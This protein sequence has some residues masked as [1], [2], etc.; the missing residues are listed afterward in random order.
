[1]RLGK[2]T[3]LPWTVAAALSLASTGLAHGQS[4]CEEAF[5]QAEKSYNLGLFEDVPDQLAP[6]LGA[7]TSRALAVQVHYL[8]ARTYLASDELDKARQEIS[9]ILRIDSSF[10]PAG[11]P[12]RFAE[13]IAEI[14]REEATVQVTSV[15]KTKES[16]REVP[17]TVVVITADEIE[18]RGY[19]DLE[20]LLHDLPGFDISRTNG[21]FYS[22]I[23]QRGFRSRY[24]DRNLFLLDG[25]EQNDPSSNVLYLSRQYPLSNIDRV[26][27][28]YGPA[29]T[30]YGANAYTGVINIIT[31][32]P[33]DL[34]GADQRFGI[35]VQ[36][37]AGGFDARSADLSLAGKDRNGNLAWSLAGHLYRSD[38]MDLSRFENWNFKYDAIDYRSLLSLAG[39][40]AQ[41]F[42]FLCSGS[43]S[44]Y[45]DCRFDEGGTLTAIELTSAG[46][47]VARALD[48]SFIQENQ[49]HF[50]D[51]TDDWALYGKMRIA[52]LT[53]G[54]DVWRVDEGLAS[55]FI[56]LFVDGR[57]T[58]TSRQLSFYLQYSRSAG[59][60]LTFNAFTRF[61]QFAIDKAATDIS[62]PHLYANSL[63]GIWNLVPPCALPGDPVEPSGCPASPWFEQRLYGGTSSQIRSEYTLVYEPAGKLSAVGGLELARG[64]IGVQD[65]VATGPGGVTLFEI[66]P[67]QIEHTDLGLYAQA[68]YKLRS[69]LK[70]VLA[71]RLSYNEINNK[72]SASGFGTLF[73]PRMAIVYTPGRR[74][75]KAIYSEAFKD[76]TDF[77]KFGTLP[78][79]YDFPS[80]GL[81]PEKVKNF[82]VSAGWQPTDA[83]SLEAAAYEARYT[84]LVTLRRVPGCVQ[85]FGCN[86]LQNHDQLRIRG[87]QVTAQYR[88]GRVGLWSNYTYTNPV[89]RNPEDADGQPLLDNQGNVIDE[90]RVADIASHRVNLGLDFDFLTRFKAD[91]RLHYIGPRPTGRGT[92]VAANPLSQIDSSTV[93]DAALSYVDLLPGMT[94]Q[95]IVN[96]LFDREYFDPGRDVESIGAPEVPQP[97]RTVYLRI[98]T[99]PWRAGRPAE[100]RLGTAPGQ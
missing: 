13:L 74:V 48:R 92:T 18:R 89:Q 83:L 51:R 58:S 1:M 22:N 27:V 87:L 37:A 59:R 88:V 34:I 91:L 24:S 47:Q 72:P 99:R 71:G 31:K 67:E 68:S 69:M 57:S 29:S 39:P 96:N 65:L 80:G 97:G 42:G 45:Y 78:F 9:T 40:A 35:T 38:E 61:Q 46:E 12:P 19:L 3:I 10:E 90:L 26:E 2:R 94:L 53:I 41:D 86:Q 63:L 60:D 98:I 85:I 11:P 54:L 77:E 30:M 64:S 75:F 82:E 93:A 44:P 76:P 62:V 73:T 84:D 43:P 36:G 7:K 52:N 66:Q 33:E 16:L 28:I 56:D 8:L 32:K 17:A 70:L 55:P 15:S 20:Q 81:R 25:V 5:Q 14:R 49:V 23:N 79:V 95:L 50:D 21:E 100:R 6:C 4:S